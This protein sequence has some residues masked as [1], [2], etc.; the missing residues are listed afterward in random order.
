MFLCK[1]CIC[2]GRVALIYNDSNI[3]EQFSYRVF[4]TS[5]ISKVFKTCL[6]VKFFCVI[7][8]N[9][10]G[11]VVAICDTVVHLLVQVCVIIC[12]FSPTK[13]L[14][15]QNV[16][17]QLR[18]QLAT[19]SFIVVNVRIVSLV[20]ANS[21]SGTKSQRILYWHRKLA[22]GCNFLGVGTLRSCNRHRSLARF[23]LVIVP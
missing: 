15:G 4:E 23:H 18:F 6:F 22:G 11:F 3:L 19:S 14:L 10:W 2:V 9:F 16:N 5:Y 1:R 7:K 13:Y 21:I 12:V 8:Y 17:V 20:V